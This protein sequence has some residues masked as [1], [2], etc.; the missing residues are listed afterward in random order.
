MVGAKLIWSEQ[1]EAAGGLVPEEVRGEIE[2]RLEY[3]RRMPSMYAQTADDRF[4][5]CRSFWVD[6]TYRVYY[7]VGAMGRDVYIAAIL[8][9]E[10]EGIE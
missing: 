7:M 9:E 5:G 3:V 6:P 1:A 8:E 10:V 4:P 2:R